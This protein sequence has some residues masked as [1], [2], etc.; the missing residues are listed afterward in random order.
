MVK[1]E[2]KEEGKE[3]NQLSCIGTMETTM[4]ND[5]DLVHSH[6]LSSIHL[7]STESALRTKSE[8]SPRG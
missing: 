5:E 8:G 1:R 7:A 3:R 2:R 6:S 4:K